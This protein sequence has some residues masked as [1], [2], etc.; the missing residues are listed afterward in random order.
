[1]INKMVTTINLSGALCAARD[2]A[3]CCG[4]RGGGSAARTLMR[5]DGA[6]QLDWPSGCRGDR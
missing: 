5:V 1:M 6:R 4:A 2:R 3:E